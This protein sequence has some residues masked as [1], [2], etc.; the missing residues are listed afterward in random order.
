MSVYRTIGPIV[1]YL[2]L[3]ALTF[4][5][6]ML[7]LLYVSLICNHSNFRATSID[8]NFSA[9]QI[10]CKDDMLLLKHTLSPIVQLFQTNLEFSEH[11]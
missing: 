5:Y 11:Y 2:E 9:L 3:S 10:F 8:K 7:F 6:S 4:T 1:S